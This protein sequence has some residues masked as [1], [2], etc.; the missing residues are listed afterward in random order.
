MK[1]AASLRAYKNEIL[2]ETERNQMKQINDDKDAKVFSFYP[3]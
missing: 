1:S 2:R 3:N